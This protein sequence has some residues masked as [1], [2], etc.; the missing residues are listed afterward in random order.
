M[1]TIEQLIE[2]LI[3]A[4]KE[5]AWSDGCTVILIWEGVADHLDALWDS[6]D[7]NPERASRRFVDAAMRSLSAAAR[8]TDEY[9]FGQSSDVSRYSIACLL[10]SALRNLERAAAVPRLEPSGAFKRAGCV[11]LTFAP[12]PCYD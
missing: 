12:E 10:T 3:V 11:A 1:S 7:W 9:V 6:P 5:D 4:I 8:E 2:Q